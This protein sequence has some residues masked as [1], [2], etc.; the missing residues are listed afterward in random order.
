MPKTSLSFKALLYFFS[1]ATTFSTTG[2]ACTNILVMPGASADGSMILV[3]TDDNELTDQRMLYVPAANHK[4]KLRAVYPYLRS[5]PRYV[6]KNRGPE[7]QLKGYPPTKPLGYIE[8]V[9]HT[10][11]YF[12]AEY[13]ILNQYQLGFTESTNAAKVSPEPKPGKR[14]FDENHPGFSPSGR[15]PGA[16]NSCR[17]N[18]V[19]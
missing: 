16:Q 1:L 4:N 6:G 13:A 12:D 8:Q 15:P 2:F 17:R 11:A 19:I 5:Y 14:I 3:H 7:Y 10:Y 18:F 9:S